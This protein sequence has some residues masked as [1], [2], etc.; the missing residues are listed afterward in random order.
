MAMHLVVAIC[1]VAVFARFLPLTGQPRHHEA[2]V[3]SGNR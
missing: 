3:V 1:A 2:S